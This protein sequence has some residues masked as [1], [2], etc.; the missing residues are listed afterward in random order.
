TLLGF[1]TP[2]NVG[3]DLPI[4]IA[5]TLEAPPYEV[6]L[7]DAIVRA[8]N[9]RPV[10]EAL[11]STEKLRSEEVRQNRAAYIPQLSAIAGYGWQNRNF[12]RDL[13]QELHGWNLGAQLSWDIWDG[14]LTRGRVQSAKAREEKARIEVVDA[15]RQVELEVRIAHSSFIEARE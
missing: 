4:Q 13:S 6:D 10:L 9:Q 11:R 5:G 14:N 1:D 3:Q 8:L 2:S 12:V 7:A 15:A